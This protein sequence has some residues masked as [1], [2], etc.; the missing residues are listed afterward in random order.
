MKKA[1]VE[2]EVNIASNYQAMSK[3]NKLLIS[4]EGIRILDEE[5][6]KPT[7]LGSFSENIYTEWLPITNNAQDLLAAMENIKILIFVNH[8]NSLIKLLMDFLEKYLLTTNNLKEADTIFTDDLTEILKK[9]NTNI[10]NI[11][12]NGKQLREGIIPQVLLSFC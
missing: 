4:E 5:N 7:L 10:Y 11:I 8:E 6:A 2:K 12:F 3:D 1:L 9:R